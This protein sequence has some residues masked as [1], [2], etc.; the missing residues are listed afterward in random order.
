MIGEHVPDRAEK[1]ERMLELE[2]LARD[3]G[4]MN[5][6]ERDELLQ[7]LE[8]FRPRKPEHVAAAETAPFYEATHVLVQA[9]L[10]SSSPVPTPVY[11]VAE[12]IAGKL[13]HL[14]AASLAQLTAARYIAREDPAINVDDDARVSLADDS[15]WVQAWVRV[16]A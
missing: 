8:E 13:R 4:R 12:V 11:E 16:D 3:L 5:H 6:T 10:L 1:L 2:L 9:I 7:L 15:V 14:P